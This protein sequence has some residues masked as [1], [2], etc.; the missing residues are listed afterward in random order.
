MSN[1][2]P[3]S[4]LPPAESE[5]QKERALLRSGANYERARLLLAAKRSG[6][7]LTDADVNAKIPQTIRLDFECG[8]HRLVWKPSPSGLLC[9]FQR[10][11]CN[12]GRGADFVCCHLCAKWLLSNDQRL[13]EW[14]GLAYTVNCKA[15]EFLKNPEGFRVFWPVPFE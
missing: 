14:F 10:I 1:L 8:V 15:A 5:A 2:I 6:Q 4:N 12:G 3:L 13:R 9:F 7:R 11:P